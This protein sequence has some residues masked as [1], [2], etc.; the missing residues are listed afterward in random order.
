M[1]R[2]VYV[3]YVCAVVIHTS[4]N[5]SFT[6]RICFS[7]AKVPLKWCCA[8]KSSNLGQLKVESFTDERR[9]LSFV[10]ITVEMR[11]GM[12]MEQAFATAA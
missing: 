10:F 9:R 1:Q 12:M 7:H 5:G 6:V 3:V 2:C 8:T 11:S 4:L